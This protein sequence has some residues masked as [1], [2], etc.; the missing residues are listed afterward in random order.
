MIYDFQELNQLDKI[1]YLKEIKIDIKKAISLDYQT[2]LVHK[3]FWPTKEGHWV[4][5]KSITK[6]IF[7]IF[8]K[9]R[10]KSIIDKKIN[11]EYVFF[12]DDTHRVDKIRMFNSIVKSFS[13]EKSFSII[14][15]LPKLTFYKFDNIKNMIKKIHLTYNFISNFRLLKKINFQDKLKLASILLKC[16]NDYKELMN[17]KF[18]Q[19]SKLFFFN[20]N[21]YL[22]NMICQ[23]ANIKNITTFA[24][25]HS[26][27]EFQ[28]VEYPRMFDSFVYSLSAKYHLCWGKYNKKG[29]EDMLKNTKTKFLVTCHPLRDQYQADIKVL[30]QET[31]SHMIVLLAQKKHFK[32]N[33]AL[34]KLVK[35]FVNKS[36]FTYTIKLHPSDNENNYH[37][38]DL[39]DKLLNEVVNQEEFIEDLFNPNSICVFFRTSGYL[40]L[41]SKGVPTFKYIDEQEDYVG[42]NSFNSLEK[43]E[44]L[45]NSK[46]NRSLWYNNEV[47]PK[48]N[49]MYGK[50]TK[51]P[52]SVYRKIICEKS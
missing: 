26:I 15:N 1:P 19:K 6:I 7:Q 27:L 9:T 46:N 29:Y 40:E 49:S 16:F 30:R 24:C 3:Y 22:Q 12:F 51:D 32:E 10:V 2:I 36:K 48:L 18:N 20:E 43:L 45:I 21:Y 14:K 13:R 11:S 42:V 28:K 47:L 4:F 17:L 50:F 5:F 31:Y 35:K 52:S 39:N 33:Y 8:F 34:I 41:V 44:R 38:I 25:D 37:N 23:I